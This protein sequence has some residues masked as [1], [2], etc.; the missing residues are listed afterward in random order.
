[1]SV[2]I[3]SVLASHTKWIAGDGGEQAN[4]Q[5]ANLQWADLQSANLRW[6]N[7]LDTGVIAAQIGP[8]WAICT[9]DEMFVGCERHSHEHWAGLT[10]DQAAEMPEGENLWAYRPLLMEMM[11]RCRVLGWPPERDDKEEGGAR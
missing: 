9:P 8:F 7:L 4:L 3:A 2:D 10:A 1:M 6:A 11:R 5:W